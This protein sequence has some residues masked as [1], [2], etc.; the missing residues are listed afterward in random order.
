MKCSNAAFYAQG[1]RL[2][3]VIV[4][5]RAVKIYEAAVEALTKKERQDE[6][7]LHH[8]NWRKN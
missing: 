4:H 7:S 2:N 8:Q 3:I 1:S 5:V 6:T